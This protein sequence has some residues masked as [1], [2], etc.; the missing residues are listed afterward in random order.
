MVRGARTRYR[1]LRM[2]APAEGD[3]IV[4]TVATGS[5]SGLTALDRARHGV[6]ESVRVLVIAG[7]AR[8]NDTIDVLGYS[9]VSAAPE[10]MLGELAAR[11]FHAVLLDLDG[12][13][14]SSERLLDA[15]TRASPPTPAIVVETN[16]D[17]T[18]SRAWLERGADDHIARAVLSPA[19]LRRSI[20]ASVAR[21]RARQLRRRLEHADRLAAIGTLAAGVAHEVNNPA[22]YVLM[23]LKTCREH[24]AELRREVGGPSELFD[25]I[26]EMLDDNLRG[27]E[28]IVAIVQSLRSY[29]RTDPDEIEAVD[30]AAVCQD[31]HALI[32]NQLRHRARLAVELAPVPPIAADARKMSQ[33]VINL[34]VNAADAIESSSGD[35]GREP[36]ILLRCGTR[37]G[38]VEL[39]VTDTGVG[40]PAAYR[41][42]I[43]DPFFTTKPRGSGSGLGLSIVR[44]IVERFGGRIAV[45]ST[46]GR[47]TTFTIAFPVDDRAR[48]ARAAPQLAAAPS[49]GTVLII[50]DEVALTS[51]LRRQLRAHH[52]VTVINDGAAGL[53]AALRH[54]YDVILCDIM[55]P[56]T[57][58]IVVLETLR[59]N[60]PEV[61]PRLVLMTAGVTA[62]PMR[63]RV[64]TAGGQLLD[65]P[66][67]LETLLAMI[68]GVRRR[69]ES[70][71]ACP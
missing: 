5:T 22:A 39:S 65:K 50:D 45:D 15:L 38:R 13:G 19:V 12:L 59:R 1:F 11:H 16:A 18:R 46:T 66:V 51:A 70:T 37:D 69:R 42:R 27:V 52:D 68:D 67:P 54:D 8:V 7:D 28:R 14:G 48:S 64:L 30:L 47:G 55:M 4:E 23:N 32:G 25:E 43:Y 33:V 61:V 21:S 71:S 29:A 49:R 40:I 6:A 56:G 57:D 10:E 2:G 17:E 9:V 63:E 36:E 41:A 26:T 44:D 58:G 34:L 62:D 53:A 31:A 3:A 60:R 20:E 35:D 24:I